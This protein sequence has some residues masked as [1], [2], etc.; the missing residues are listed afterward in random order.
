MNI[1]GGGQEL[2]GAKANGLMKRATNNYKLESMSPKDGDGRPIGKFNFL[3]I[4]TQRDFNMPT[5]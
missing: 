3:K 4:L 2:S 5:A 1:R